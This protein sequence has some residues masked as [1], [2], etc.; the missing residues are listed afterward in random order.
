MAARIV[1]GKIASP[2]PTPGF[3][4]RDLWPAASLP[5]ATLLLAGPGHGKTLGLLSM[6]R[7]AGAEGYAVA[8]LTFDELDGDPVTVFEHLIAAVRLQVPPFGRETEAL[9]GTVEVDPRVLWQAFLRELAAYNARPGIILVLDE[10]QHL[11]AALPEVARALAFHLDKLPA[12]VHLMMASRSR[13]AAPLE[14]LIGLGVLRQLGPVELRLSD[15]EAHR[16]WELRQGT[17]PPP[18]WAGV[19]RG[20]EGWP[21]GVAFAAARPGSTS[22]PQATN[23][24]LLRYIAEEVYG[25]QP[26]DLQDLMVRSAMLLAPSAAACE[27]ASGVATAAEGLE[28][29]V[30][31]Q[32][33]QDLGDGTYRYAGYL[34]EF[35][36]REAGRRL[37]PDER[38]AIHARAG[39]HYLDQGQPEWAFAH[40]I[41]A[42][43]WELAVTTLAQQ[44][45]IMLA[46]GGQAGLRRWLEAFPADRQ[47][48][49][50][51]Q[52]WWGQVAW[53]AGE[54][55]R[56]AAH[57]ER[58]LAGFEA[59]GDARGR[60][61]AA[62]RLYTIAVTWQDAEAIARHAA[63][64]HALAA[65]GGDEDRADL[66]LA[67]ALAADQR[68]DLDAW[69]AANEA[70]L[71][72]PVGTGIEVAQ[73]AM[74]ADMNLFTLA[75]HRG[76]LG[77]ARRHVDET[78]ALAQAWS[79]HA[80]ALFAGI[81][82]A[83]LQTL[84]GDTAAAAAFLR[85]LP[86]SWEEALDWHDRASAWFILGAF[87]L[88]LGDGQAA[89][90]H[91][92]RSAALFDKVG[93]P[94]GRKLPLERQA[95]LALQRERPQDALRSLERAGELT[96]SS[97]YDLALRLVRAR[98]R[99]LTGET[100]VALAEL[101]ELEADARAMRAPLPAVRARLYTAAARG[102]A[103]DPEGARA[104]LAEALRELEAEGY[105]FLRG[106]D[107][108]LWRELAPLTQPA[109]AASTPAG[110]GGQVGL[111]LFG[112][113]EARLDGVLLE[114]WPRR[115]AKVV[116]A[117]LALA[118]RGLPG[119]VLAELL[120]DRTPRQAGVQM[121]VTA[122]RRQFEP[123]LKDGTR[124]RYVVLIDD[125]YQ[126]AAGP[127]ESCDVAAF[128]AD[129]QAG[130]RARE[131]DPDGA[132]ARLEAGLAHYRGNLLDEPFFE[133]YFEAERE[134]LRRQA[135]EALCWLHERCVF[136][137]DDKAGLAHLERA[138]AL[139]PCD[140]E[141]AIAG[142][143]FHGRR[144]SPERVRAVYWDHRK[145]LH[146]L[147]GLVPSLEVEA[148]Y[149]AALKLAGG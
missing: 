130:L 129:L 108:A 52:F 142:M 21:L 28:R 15:A 67:E 135:I 27:A 111:R 45:P 74:I 122:L 121:C 144:R 145:A 47:E 60:T 55:A 49:P 131:A 85:D 70:V 109:E 66:H 35:L 59:S 51:L 20:Y 36:L 75:L 90:E 110:G 94:L 31:A 16:L 137:G 133:P 19:V 139:A 105:A 8:W 39:R 113:F 56:A 23:A 13:P 77:R 134:G 54:S 29:L 32:V 84:E 18:D 91:L 126:L 124:S 120:D 127:L 147:L 87:H 78:L 26:A 44:A 102:H 1:L 93:F 119:A 123:E 132:R 106:Q 68:G 41:D 17:P 10:L 100:E 79:F 46:R 62:I 96:R 14:R 24:M 103:G 22:T 37:P 34:R 2:A 63:L 72:L 61:K 81:L 97:V 136:L 3:V 138:F 128:L 38:Q 40:L 107:A 73:C 143:R 80:E 86:P 69:Q 5:S 4:E 30:D 95:W 99:A 9:L 6:A 48:H 83:H 12:G 140:D 148:G 125:R 112:S 7:R 101:A 149:Q 11:Q 43:A 50:W 141:V 71:G 53:R 42:E 57:H 114:H 65:T 116:L 89:E 146:R 58:A 25:A 115:K 76:D 118:P 82:R 92:A 104:A 98:A 33:L 64:A 117:A 88:A